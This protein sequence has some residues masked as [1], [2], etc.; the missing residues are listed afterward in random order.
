MMSVYYHSNRVCRTSE[1]LY[2][3]GYGAASEKL[4]LQGYGATSE[5]QCQPGYDTASERLTLFNPRQGA[6]AAWGMV[7]GLIVLRGCLGEARCTIVRY[8]SQQGVTRIAR[9]KAQ[10]A[11]PRLEGNKR[12]HEPKIPRLRLRLAW[13]YEECASP[14]H[15]DGLAPFS[16]RHVHK[17]K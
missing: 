2:L 17:L 15:V 1:R 16:P 14:R 9:L 7:M 6:A 12:R 13:G 8:D 11:S 4:R 3:R 5:K 10:S